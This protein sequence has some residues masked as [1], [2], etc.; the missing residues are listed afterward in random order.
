MRGKPVE[1]APDLPF[2]GPGTCLPAC[3]PACMHAWVPTSGLI[4]SCPACAARSVC[5]RLAPQR[6]PTVSPLLMTPLHWPALT[7]PPHATHMHMHRRLRPREAAA[8]RAR[9]H[10]AWPPARPR[11]PALAWPRRVRAHRRRPRPRLDHG[12]AAARP[13]GG[14]RRPAR[15]RRVRPARVSHRP[16]LHHAAAAAGA[17]QR[18]ASRIAL[19]RRGVC[20]GCAQESSR[21]KDRM[22]CVCVRV[23]GSP[24]EDQHFSVS[25]ITTRTIT[26]HAAG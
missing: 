13:P 15:T 23:S 3:L 12:R 10:P 18:G 20:A 26:L 25:F 22:G 4:H 21:K 16:G 17:A 5:H 2:V 11:A 14:G 6:R 8:G 7:T 9:L 24:Q 19:Y 1:P